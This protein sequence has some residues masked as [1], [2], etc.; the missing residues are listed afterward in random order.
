MSSCAAGTRTQR[1]SCILVPPFARIAPPLAR[2]TDEAE[3]RRLASR[4]MGFR[5]D[6]PPESLAAF[7]GAIW[8]SIAACSQT[9]SRPHR[10]PS[11]DTGTCHAP[12]HQPSPAPLKLAPPWSRASLSMSLLACAY[13]PHPRASALPSTSSLQKSY[14]TS[15]LR[16][17]RTPSSRHHQHLN[18]LHHD[19]VFF[20]HVYL[21]VGTTCGPSFGQQC[22]FPSPCPQ[23]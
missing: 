23:V 15:T 17:T 1:T 10:P 14:I 2:T 16:R 18:S 6:N 4:H 9:S 20:Q 12:H 7:R 3:S 22:I 21:P 19:H 8:I 13:N 5:I 11:I